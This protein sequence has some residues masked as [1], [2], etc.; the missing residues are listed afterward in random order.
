MTQSRTCGS[1]HRPVGTGDITCPHCGAWLA[2]YESAMDAPISTA[3]P[4]PQPVPASPVP[5]TSTAASPPV[6]PRRSVMD[7]LLKRSQLPESE[8]DPAE[9]LAAM[10]KADSAFAEQVEAELQGAKVVMDGGTTSVIQTAPGSG[11]VVVELDTPGDDSPPPGGIRSQ[12]VARSSPGSQARDST[13]SPAKQS[14]PQRQ[15]K[16]MLNPDWV[17]SPPRRQPVQTSLPDPEPPATKKQATK[18]NGKIYIVAFVL[19]LIFSF[20]NAGTGGVAILVVLL[21]FGGF[22]FWFGLGITKSGGRLTGDMPLDKDIL[23]S[24]RDRHR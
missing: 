24:N 5:E 14:P 13:A 17:P 3:S 8:V 23:K 19:F 21:L 22:A 1:C 6:Q 10:A 12:P 20:R 4:A 2:A 7:D 15:A 9:E 11:D 16:T 18:G